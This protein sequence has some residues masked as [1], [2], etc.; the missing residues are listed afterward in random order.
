MF[1]GS[2]VV[3]SRMF[4]SSPAEAC[5]L[6]P[7]SKRQLLSDILGCRFPLMAVEHPIEAAHV[8]QTHALSMQIMHLAAC[9]QSRVCQHAMPSDA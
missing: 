4:T 7:Y 3:T 8:N 9:G 1:S 6:L 2:R 5:Q